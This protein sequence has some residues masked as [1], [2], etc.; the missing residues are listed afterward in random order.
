MPVVVIALSEEVQA[1]LQK[2]YQAMTV[3]W[4]GLG[5]DVTQPTFEQWLAQRAAGSENMPTPAAEIDNLRTFHAVEKFVTSL[6]RHGFELVNV[7]KDGVFSDNSTHELARAIVTDLKLQ[8]QYLKRVQDLLEHY[9]KSVQEVTNVAT[10]FVTN[11]G[12][13]IL[14]DTYTQLVDRATN[15][16]AELGPE[17]A[18]GRVEGAA[19]M[20]VSVEAMDRNEAQDKTDVFK[21]HARTAPRA[22]WVGKVLRNP[23]GKE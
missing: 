22:T 11:R 14:T 6:R 2:Q 21:I 3:H 15:G 10:M 12:R 18:I 7:G 19:A 13:A 8:P 23:K 5:P 4:S 17:R 20:L 16:I 1:K 9:L